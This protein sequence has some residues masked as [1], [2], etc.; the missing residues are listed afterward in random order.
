PG[1]GDVPLASPIDTAHG[2]D[3]KEPLTTLE[4]PQV[5]VM[6]AILTLWHVNKKHAN[7]T[8]TFDTS[9]SMRENRKM[10]NARAAA[11][12]LVDQLSDDDQF[13]LLPFSGTPEWAMQRVSI[14]EGRA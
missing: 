11:L 13:S 8:L 4:V 5:D 7:I 6:H 9:G 14:R 1:A 2:V 3:P 10:E 12:Q